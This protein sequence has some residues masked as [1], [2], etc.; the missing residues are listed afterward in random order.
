MSRHRLFLVLMAAG[1]L[2]VVAQLALHRRMAAAVQPFMVEPD[3]YI[4]I[5]NRALRGKL[6][7]GRP[8]PVRDDDT[9][10]LGEVGPVEGEASPVVEERLPEQVMTVEDKLED[11]DRGFL[12]SSFLLEDMQHPIRFER[13]KDDSLVLRPGF[14]RRPLPFAD[15]GRWQ[16]RILFRDG[17]R[18]RVVRTWDGRELRLTPDPDGRARAIQVPFRAPRPDEDPVLDG[19]VFSWS[20]GN[21]TAFH[22]HALPGPDGSGTACIP[23]AARCCA[24]SSR[25][26]GS[27]TATATSARCC[28]STTAC[29]G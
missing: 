19:S 12:V 2:L 26:T 8:A 25:A 1:F 7:L 28:G 3:G 9:G 10:F 11:A 14:R 18:I 27:S 29:P 5:V 15:S 23:T 20:T 13:R 21:E 17:G 24:L 22:I 4:E 6:V 16:G